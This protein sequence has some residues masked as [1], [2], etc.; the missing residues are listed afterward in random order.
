MSIE[1]LWNDIRL[2]YEGLNFSSKLFI[3]DL[4]I[5]SQD[6][7]YLLCSGKKW[8]EKVYIRKQNEIVTQIRIEKNLSLVNMWS[9]NKEVD[10]VDYNIDV[11]VDGQVDLLT[12][13]DKNY[14]IELTYKI[15]TPFLRNCKLVEIG[16]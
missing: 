13:K 6:N 1:Q 12:I 7:C 4:M 10:I 3:D 5:I 2:I 16:I 11:A 15:I 8:D 14:K 9:D